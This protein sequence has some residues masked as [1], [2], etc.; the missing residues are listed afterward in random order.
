MNNIPSLLR[1]GASLAKTPAQRAKVEFYVEQFAKRLARCH[2]ML[3]EINAIG[4][5]EQ[6][7]RRRKA[8]A[9]TDKLLGR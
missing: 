6:N 9:K 3:D 4:L 1:Q 7:E 5:A 2:A 8:I